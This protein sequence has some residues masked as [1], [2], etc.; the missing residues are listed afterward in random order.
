MPKPVQV[1]HGSGNRFHIRTRLHGM[2][3][4]DVD[5]REFRTFRLAAIAL[6]NRMALGGAELKRGEVLLCADWYAPESILKMVRP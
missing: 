3:R 1:C 5:Q 4:W 6:G 2:H